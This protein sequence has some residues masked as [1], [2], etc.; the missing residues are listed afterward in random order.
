M[1]KDKQ[2][3]DAERTAIAPQEKL[4]QTSLLSDNFPSESHEF[5]HEEVAEITG[6]SKATVS[7]YWSRG[8]TVTGNERTF[9]PTK[10]SGIWEE[11]TIP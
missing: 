3:P 6:K 5:T 2:L 10:K 1:A 7:P 9:K 11:I 8:K 4:S